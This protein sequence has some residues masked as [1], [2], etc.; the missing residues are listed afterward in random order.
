MQKSEAALPSI[1][2]FKPMPPSEI[3]FFEVNF[4]VVSGIHFYLTRLCF[5]CD[6]I[7]CFIQ[8]DSISYE[9]Y[10]QSAHRHGVEYGHPRHTQKCSRIQH[11]AGSEDQLNLCIRRSLARSHDDRLDESVQ[12]G[13]CRLQRDR[14]K[15]PALH[16][17]FARVK[18]LRKPNDRLE[19]KLD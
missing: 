3:S 11:A 17:N 9:L 2:N 7:R 16:Q 18:V 15:V 6:A 5:P 8:N 13:A 12:G 14:C 10:S 19:A 4:V 1:S